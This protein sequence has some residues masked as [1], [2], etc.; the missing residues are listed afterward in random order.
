M[1]YN[2]A[3]TFFTMIITYIYDKS[4]Y[5]KEFLSNIHF[6]KSYYINHLYIKSICIIIILIIILII[7]Y[8][9]NI[10]NN[11]NQVIIEIHNTD[12]ITFIIYKFMKSYPEF[13]PHI[14]Q[15]SKIIQNNISYGEP[16]VLFKKPI[17]FYDNINNV[18]GRLEFSLK[19]YT[20]Y[21]DSKDKL[22]VTKEMIIV[23]L[24]ID[25]YTLKKSYLSIIEQMNLKKDTDNTFIILNF[26]KIFNQTVIEKNYYKSLKINRQIDLQTMI[27]SYYS[28]YKYIL[29]NMI[30]KQ[31]C[32]IK[33]YLLHGPPG[34][35]K[36]KFINLFST[37]I[38]A[39]IISINLY[40]YVNRKTDLYKLFYSNQIIVQNEKGESI[41]AKT[42]IRHIQCIVLE[43]I[44]YSII[45]INKFHKMQEVVNKSKKNENLSILY[46]N[47]NNN[48]EKEYLHLGDLLE[49]FQGLIDFPDR[50]ILATTNN[51]D[52]I[53]NLCPALFR[54]GRLTPLF[55]DYISWDILNQICI[56]YYKQTIDHEPIE[57]KMSTAEIIE[58]IKYYKTNNKSFEEFQKHMINVLKS[59]IIL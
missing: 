12:T 51:I 49:L 25:N 2:F 41:Q 18:T 24:I 59:K 28:P 11:N 39:D 27:D 19:T 8:I 32:D 40:D 56:D 4:G 7:K 35:G 20:V 22:N 10:I 31:S 29:Q 50:Y 30:N 14:H 44:D 5:V 53:K 13:F 57:I 43:E 17:K 23:K 9:I 37:T 46:T 26:Y 21:A 1:Q 58:T 34:T 55:I 36:S 48:D 38:E 52:S 45:K 47:N 16:R 3:L 33:N 54:P 6:A 42:R 15:I